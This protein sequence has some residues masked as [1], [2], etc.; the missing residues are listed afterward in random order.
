ME[1]LF[2][3]VFSIS[4]DLNSISK[5]EVI[6]VDEIIK[7]Y[8]D[9]FKVVPINMTKYFDEKIL[10]LS[11]LSIVDLDHNELQFLQLNGLLNEGLIKPLYLD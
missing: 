3:A 5:A 8:K 10:K 7:K 1:N 4:R 11:N 6:K 2:G 9:N